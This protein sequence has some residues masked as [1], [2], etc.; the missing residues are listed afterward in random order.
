[1]IREYDESGKVVWTYKLDLGDRNP[2]GGHGPEGHGDHCYSAYRLPSGNTL[3]GG[4]NNNRVLE[5][6]PAGKIVWSIDQ[7]ELPGITLAW[8]TM[9]EAL[10]NGDVIVDNCHA[11]P[12]LLSI[13]GKSHSG[14]RC[15][16]WAGNVCPDVS[17][18]AVF[19]GR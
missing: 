7:K 8:V 4:G 2:S 19:S 3:I 1:M 11:G 12:K 18:T 14:N 9:L 13:A 17:R 10:P 15:G 16:P 6:S 5:V